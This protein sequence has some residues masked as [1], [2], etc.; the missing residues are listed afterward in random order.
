MAA[1]VAPIDE[2]PGVVVA[3]ISPSMGNEPRPSENRKIKNLIF[4]LKVTIELP[5]CSSAQ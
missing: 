4:L 3:R 2:E 5:H 1:S